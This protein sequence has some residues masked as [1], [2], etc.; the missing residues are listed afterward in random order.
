[1]PSIEEWRQQQE[2]NALYKLSEGEGILKPFLEVGHAN[3]I[4]SVEQ[5]KL[6]STLRGVSRWR[7]K[8][9]K[10]IDDFCDSV[11]DYQLTIGAPVNSR[12]QLLDAVKFKQFAEHEKSRYLGVLPSGTK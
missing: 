1:M 10:W 6:L 2:Q 5:A 7:G 3:R 4:H 9:W 8:A 11:E 12:T